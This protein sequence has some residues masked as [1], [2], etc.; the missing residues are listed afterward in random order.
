MSFSRLRI[1]GPDE[2]PGVLGA[3]LH[4]HDGDF[5]IGVLDPVPVGRDGSEVCIQHFKHTDTAACDRVKIGSLVLMELVSFIAEQFTTVTAITVVLTREATGYGDG[6]RLARERSA[7]LQSIG[8]NHIVITPKPLAERA[9]HFVV[10]GVWEYNQANLAA[11]AQAVERE[12]AAYVERRDALPFQNARQPSPR[13]WL[14]R[15]L[16]R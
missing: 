1:T 8:A 2:G 14:D 11:L 10:T 16:G 7:L 6:I 5:H 4:V 3:P 9:G 12:R 15:L 13:A